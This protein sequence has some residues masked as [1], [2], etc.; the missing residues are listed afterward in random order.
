MY[1]DLV[2]RVRQV[3]EEV[4]D[5]YDVDPYIA[6]QRS[7]VIEEAAGAI[8]ALSKLALDEHNRAAIAAWDHRW[9]PVT[10][11]LPK[12]MQYVLVRYKNN[13]M[14]VASWFGG[15]EHIRFW[16]AM[17]DEGWCADCDTEPTH[18]MPLPEPPK[19]K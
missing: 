4:C 18:W 19:E 13:D 15:D 14:A 9:V 11:R 7:F 16:R 1:E 17:T 8:E 6:E 2:K 5:D 3:A 10:E 12:K